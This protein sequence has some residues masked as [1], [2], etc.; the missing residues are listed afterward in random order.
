MNYVVNKFKRE[1]W[2]NIYINRQE[3]K[4]FLYGEIQELET[5][6]Y[7]RFYLNK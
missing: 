7:F 4:M 6:V 2:T 5:L 3:L 1:I